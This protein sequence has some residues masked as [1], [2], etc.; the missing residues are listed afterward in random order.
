MSILKPQTSRLKAHHALYIFILLYFP[1][2][3]AAGAV[4]TG[5][6]RPQALGSP[7]FRALFL[8]W[9]T[10]G[11]ACMVLAIVLWQRLVAGIF[12]RR[13]T[14]LLGF[15][16]LAAFVMGI[17]PAYITVEL[18]IKLFEYLGN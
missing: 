3:L 14:W 1:L 5:D 16:S 4:F 7:L 11:F 17:P 12:P 9:L 18:F 15:L 8:L 13:A 2:L 6:F 10:D